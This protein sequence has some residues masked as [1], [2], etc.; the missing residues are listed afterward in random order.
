MP[1][2]IWLIK[3]QKSLNQ[4]LD[5]LIHLGLILTTGDRFIDPIYINKIIKNFNDVIAAGM[6]GAAVAHSLRVFDSY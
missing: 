2:K 5:V 4:N 1:I 6:E 3:L